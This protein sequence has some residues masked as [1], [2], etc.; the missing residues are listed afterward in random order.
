MRPGTEAT[1]TFREAC[2]T[3]EERDCEYCSRI[4]IK[5]WQNYNR[6]RIGNRIRMSEDLEDT[7]SGVPKL[8]GLCS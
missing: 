3:A 2:C 1:I 6:T 7:K 4:Y 8:G 5:S